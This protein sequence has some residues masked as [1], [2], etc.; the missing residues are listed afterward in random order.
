MLTASTSTQG[1][2]INVSDGSGPAWL[3]NAGVVEQEVNGLSVELQ[4]LL[5]GC[6]P[7]Q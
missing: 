1:L 5:R 3:D 7:G 2:V 6:C 4:L